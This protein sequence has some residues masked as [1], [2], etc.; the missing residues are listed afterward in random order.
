MSLFLL[1]PVELH[2]PGWFASEHSKPV[3]VRAATELAARQIA[4]SL[5][6]KPAVL[7]AGVQAVCRPWWNPGLVVVTW[8]R[9]LEPGLPVFGQPDVDSMQLRLQAGR[10]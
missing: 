6:G 4:S 1:T 3:Q 7:S 8:L 2:D 5:F 9:G 10:A